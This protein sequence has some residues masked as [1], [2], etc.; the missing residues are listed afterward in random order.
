MDDTD[1]ER[2]TSNSLILSNGAERTVLH[3]SPEAAFDRSLQD[4]PAEDLSFARAFL[5]PKDLT[6]IGGGG[7]RGERREWRVG[8][9]RRRRRMSGR[10]G[11]SS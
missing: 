7:E 4:R 3:S 9:S 8:G 2:P 11:I 10:R 6:L 1:T 5:T